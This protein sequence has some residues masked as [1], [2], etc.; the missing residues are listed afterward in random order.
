MGFQRRLERLQLFLHSLGA[1]G[2]HKPC[3]RQRQLAHYLSVQRKG[4]AAFIFAHRVARQ[5]HVGIVGARHDE[6]VGVVR[7]AGSHC[8][9]LQAVVAQKAQAHMTGAVMPLEHRQLDDLLRHVHAGRCARV[10]T[11]RNDLFG[12][13]QGMRGQADHPLPGAGLFQLQLLRGDLVHIE[14]IEHP[15]KPCFVHRKG[16]GVQ[17]FALL[18]HQLALFVH[19]LHRELFQIG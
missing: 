7:N 1:L 5:H 16:G 3:H 19:L 10:L 6:V 18:R 13:Q 9:A 11:E 4:K 2:A 14:G 8:A 15:R 12:S 17:H